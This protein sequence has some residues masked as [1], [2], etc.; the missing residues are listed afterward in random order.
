MPKICIPGPM[1]PDMFDGETP[2]MIEV[3]AA[4]YRVELSWLRRTG[5]NAAFTRHMNIDIGARDESEASF[6]GE[7]IV[8]KRLSNRDDDLYVDDVYMLD[9]VPDQ[10]QVDAFVRRY[11]YSP[12]ADIDDDTLA[13]CR[14]LSIAGGDDG[15][16]LEVA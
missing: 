15:F 12:D 11:M 14:R 1:H 3:D 10:D 7:I 6:V 13:Y 9:V 4:L 5:R 8:G 16:A 2:V